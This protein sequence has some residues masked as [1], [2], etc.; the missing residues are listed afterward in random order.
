MPVFIAYG[1]ND[2]NCPVEESLNRMIKHKLD[3]FQTKV[4]P[5]G[6]HAIV[7]KKTSRVSEQFLNDLVNFIVNSVE[8]NM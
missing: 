5:D 8:N 4:Y 6:G 7:D 3:R 2:T 1:E